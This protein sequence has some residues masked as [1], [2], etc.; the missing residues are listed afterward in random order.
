MII[1]KSIINNINNSYFNLIKELHQHY[2]N[3][4]IKEEYIIGPH[5]LAG[6]K[7]E[8][9]LM[10]KHEVSVD[11]YT[12]WANYTPKQV[13]RKYVIMVY[14]SL[15]TNHFQ[16][17]YWNQ[18]HLRIK[19]VIYHEV[20]HHLQRIK[21][22]FRERLDMKAYESGEIGDYINSPAEIEAYTKQLYFMHKKTKIGF[23]ALLADESMNMSPDKFTRMRFI[24]KIYKFIRKRKDLN[25]LLNIQL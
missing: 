5:V 1:Q 9:R 17:K 10:F 19:S 13:N 23:R 18:L 14:V 24:K 22:P 7:V 6:K 20:E 25:L 8:F 11:A 16:P 12:V 3:R 21:I 4:D 2:I 15:Y